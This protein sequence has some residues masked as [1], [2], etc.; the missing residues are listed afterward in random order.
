MPALLLRFLV[1]GLLAYLA[2]S[3]ITPLLY[4]QSVTAQA[5]DTL[6][7]FMLLSVGILLF[8]VGYA[9]KQLFHR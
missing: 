7:P 6:S 2:G 9:V 3:T 1:V 8:G 4:T 5:K